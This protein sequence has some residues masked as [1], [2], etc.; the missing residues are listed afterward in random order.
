MLLD[1]ESIHKEMLR[2]HPEIDP[3]RSRCYGPSGFNSGPWMYLDDL[4]G[5]P[6]G[7][8]EVF[9]RT[10]EDYHGFAVEIVRWS[11]VKK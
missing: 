1:P 2:R 9:S 8:V 5:V 3:T 6:D 11:A 10:R 4:T 7:E